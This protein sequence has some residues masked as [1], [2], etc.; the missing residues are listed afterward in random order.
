M[1]GVV[2]SGLSVTLKKVGVLFNRIERPAMGDFKCLREPYSMF[3]LEKHPS[4]PIA[5]VL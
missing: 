2:L 1:N 5:V 4:Q 3:M